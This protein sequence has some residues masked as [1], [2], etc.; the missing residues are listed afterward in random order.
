MPRWMGAMAVVMGVWLGGAGCA[1]EGDGNGVP[2]KDGP[3]DRAM[4]AGKADQIMDR[5]KEEMILL[6]VNDPRTTADELHGKGVHRRAAEEIAASGPVKSLEALDEIYFV[7]P[8]AFTQLQDA[9]RGR[10]REE[11]EV[12]VEF[13]P[14]REAGH[15]SRAVELIEDAERSVDLAIYRM[16]DRRVINALKAAARRGIEVRCLFDEANGDHLRLQGST[17]EELVEAGVE[18][19]YINRNMHHKVLLIDGVQQRLLEASETTV[20]VGSANLSYFEERRYD[21]HTVV[22]RRDVAPALALQHEFE[23]LWAHS[24]SVLGGVD[25]APVSTELEWPEALEPRGLEVWRTSANFEV[26]HSSRWGY[27]FRQL[28]DSQ[29]VARRLVA[30]IESAETEIDVAARY[31]R[32]RPILE[33]LMDRAREDGGP[34]IRVYSDQA[35]FVSAM[36]QQG[37]DARLEDCL[38]AAATEV[39][40]RHCRDVGRRFSRQIGEA[41]AALRF[42]VYGYR[43]AIARARQM[44][45]KYMV[46]DGRWL[47]MGSYNLSHN[48]ERNSMESV[49]IYDRLYYPTL[50]EAFEDNFEE[51]WRRGRGG[52]EAWLERVGEEDEIALWFEP[53]SLEMDEFQG[54]R[55]KVEKRCPVVHSEGFRERPHRFDTCE[56]EE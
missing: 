21:N 29:V 9:V 7:G 46:I 42:K 25:G 30:L 55:D 45:H 47:A 32:S 41:G 39:E 12:E 48:S 34:K 52:V 8:A 35:E 37:E 51:I 26:T 53:R 28:E 11:R 24:R 54:Y 44:H 22:H 13:A 27:G 14:S 17:S 49:L 2:E 5:C 23:H 16:S 10:C 43:W 4:V 40:K 3:M 20:M 31:L 56:A 50:V 6:W 15:I 1:V 38:L 33:A 19:R 36:D 18:V